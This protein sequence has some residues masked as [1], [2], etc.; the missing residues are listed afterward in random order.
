MNLFASEYIITNWLGDY[1]RWYR[2]LPRTRSSCLAP[3]KYA[4]TPLR[5]LQQGQQPCIRCDGGGHI[6]PRH[7][8]F[9]PIKSMAKCSFTLIKSKLKIINEHNDEPLCLWSFFPAPFGVLL[10]RNFVGSG[11]WPFYICLCYHLPH[12]CQ[13]GGPYMCILKFGRFHASMLVTDMEQ[14]FFRANTI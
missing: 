10:I 9:L 1:R 7:T 5:K 11:R 8:S 14:R 4:I 2:P 3:S 13:N 6:L 12:G